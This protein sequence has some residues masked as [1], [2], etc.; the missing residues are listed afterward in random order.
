MNLDFDL[1]VKK[2][3]NSCNLYSSKKI[4]KNIHLD[5][6]NELINITDNYKKYNKKNNYNQ[7]NEYSILKKALINYKKTIEY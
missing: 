6:I 7:E 1:I 3:S 5:N 4:T 2:Y